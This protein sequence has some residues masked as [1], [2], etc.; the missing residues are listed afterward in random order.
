MSVSKSG[1]ATAAV[2]L[3]GIVAA[4]TLSPYDARANLTPANAVIE[5]LVPPD[6]ITDD[7]LACPK[8]LVNDARNYLSDIALQGSQLTGAIDSAYEAFN[9]G[10]QK[11][12]ME[13]VI[14]AR[15]IRDK[16]VG[17]FLG[18]NS[19]EAKSPC[20]KGEISDILVDAILDS[21]KWSLR[22]DNERLQKLEK[23]LTKKTE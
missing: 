6:K 2:Y 20:V 14:N 12:F 23:R 5:T 15:Q 9:N 17:H 7:I 22:Y 4:A 13:S 10:T 18:Y 1:L 21:M 3:V 19:V 11:Q 8:K 16:V